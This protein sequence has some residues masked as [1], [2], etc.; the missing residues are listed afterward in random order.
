LLQSTLNAPAE[1]RTFLRAM[2]AGAGG[3]ALAA[4]GGGSGSNGTA[5]ANAASSPGAASGASAGAAA[6]SA[7]ASATR[8]FT[9]APTGFYGLNGHYN[10]GFA[11]NST[12]LSTQLQLMQ[13][14]GVTNTRQDLWEL[15]GAKSLVT[16]SD[17]LAGSGIQ[18]TAAI[19]PTLPPAG[20]DEDL[21]HHN[22]WQLGYAI[23]STL[24][25]RVHVYECGNELENAFINGAGDKPSDYA[26]ASYFVY[27]GMMRGLID[28]VRAADSSAAVAVTG[29]W[30]HYG[31]LQMLSDGTDPL[32][33]W[34]GPTANWDITSWHWYNDMGDIT[35]AGGNKTNVLDEL[36]RRFQRPIWIGE[37][38]YRAN[39]LAN[40]PGSALW[41]NQATYLSNAMSQFLQLKSQYNIQCVMLYELFDMPTDSGYGLVYTNPT[42]GTQQIVTSPFNGTQQEKPAYSAVKSFI[43]NNPV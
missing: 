13:D 2:A 20:T 30:L 27:R 11:Y 18:I 1:R 40:T 35:S 15:N 39:G 14:L 25:G 10:S 17:A 34:S 12:P 38:G 3:L 4:C 9:S 26:A 43:A 5:V 8:R 29:G 23:A 32:G 21:V 33:G 36:T 28:G 22:A 6:S 24:K 31:V 7:S 37:F 19:T 41:S 16:L 42:S